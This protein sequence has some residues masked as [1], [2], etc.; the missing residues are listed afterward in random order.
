MKDTSRAL[1]LNILASAHECAFSVLEPHLLKASRDQQ[2]QVLAAITLFRGHVQGHLE[3]GADPGALSRQLKELIEAQ[4][5]PHVIQL[6]RQYAEYLNYFLV[7][8]S[9]RLARPADN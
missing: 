3:A 7:Y 8:S 1:A 6:L 9:A 2:D 4:S 5:D